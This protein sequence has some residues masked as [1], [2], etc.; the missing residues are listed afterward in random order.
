MFFKNLFAREVYIRLAED[1]S[2]FA[3]TVRRGRFRIRTAVFPVA[4]QPESD[5]NLR[6]SW[7]Q[8][9]AN[10]ATRSKAPGSSNK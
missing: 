5:E 8:F 3:Y 7:N 4:S 10:A 6:C 1:C 2:G 9:L